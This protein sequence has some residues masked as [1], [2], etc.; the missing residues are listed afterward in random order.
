MVCK[1]CNVIFSLM[2]IQMYQQ[3][4]NFTTGLSQIRRAA[5]GFY[6]VK[7]GSFCFVYRES[8][9]EASKPW[10]KPRSSPSLVRWRPSKTRWCSSRRCGTIK[11]LPHLPCSG[12]RPTTRH[13]PKR[14][15]KQMN[16]PHSPGPVFRGLGLT[17]RRNA[18]TNARDP[19]CTGRTK[20]ESRCSV[21]FR[22][23]R[24]IRELEAVAK[25]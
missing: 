3:F 18:R 22:T 19:V 16:R 14:S 10:Y 8:S 13:V 15:K 1:K 9:Q 7:F 4:N 17:E 2:A 6:N 21:H 5:L 25:S 20:M 23:R 24:V 12:Y 11:V